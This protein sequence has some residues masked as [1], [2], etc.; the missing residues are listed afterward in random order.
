M[1]HLETYKNLLT[2]ARIFFTERV[3]EFSTHTVVEFIDP[4]SPVRTIHAA[5]DSDNYN[6]LKISTYC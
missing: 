1:N 2:S 6:L 4:S 3:E 5:F